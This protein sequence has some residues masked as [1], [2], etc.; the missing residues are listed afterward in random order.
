[1]GQVLHGCAKTTKAVRKEIQDSQE[2]L[3]SLAERYSLN[4]KTVQKWRK[5]SYVSDTPMGP[6]Q[7]RSTVLSPEEEAA[8]VTFRQHTLL[9]LDDCFYALQTSIPTLT[10]SSLHRLFQRHGISRLPEIE[11]KKEPRKKFQTYPIGYIHIDIAEVRTEEG[12]V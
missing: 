6:K 8:C 9:P 2:S 7:I 12:S 4:P 10:R 1:M 3:K 5:R 11:G